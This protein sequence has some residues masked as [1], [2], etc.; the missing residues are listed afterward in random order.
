M[1]FSK[2]VKK[3]V[4]IGAAVAGLGASAVDF[5]DRIVHYREYRKAEKRRKV[6]RVIFI[7]VGAIL[8][9]LFIPYRVVI[10]PDGEYEIRTLLLRVSRKNRT[11]LPG[12]DDS[13]DIEGVDEVETVEAE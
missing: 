9:V 6:M 11:D 3:F 7:T 5:A 13:F 2:I 12:A 1:K 4:S 8:A 10:K